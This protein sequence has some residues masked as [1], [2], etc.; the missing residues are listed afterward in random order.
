MDQDGKPVTGERPRESATDAD[1]RYRIDSQDRI[2]SVNSAWMRF[3]VENDAAH[4]ATQV[5]GSALWDHIHGAEVEM[6][7]R[8]LL[9]RVRRE[10]R[11]WTFPF[12]CDSS[13]AR[14]FLDM[15]VTPLPQRE[16]EF[17][18]RLIREEPRT[19]ARI[20]SP[21]V[22]RSSQWLTLCAW[23]LR[24]KVADW[25]ELDHAIKALGLFEQRVMPQVTHGL[26]DRCRNMVLDEESR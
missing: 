15:T 1:V 19:E 13:E 7:Y 21:K 18:C 22:P 11:S 6:V 26:C 16:I 10:A 24:V 12:R 25:L 14:R 9:D 23:C 17:Q 4:L 20:L 3:A 2:R 8:H 5:V